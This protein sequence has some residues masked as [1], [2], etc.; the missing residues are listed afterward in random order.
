[1]SSKWYECCLLYLKIIF[2]SFF[3]L[4]HLYWGIIAL[5]WCVSFCLITKWISYTYTCIPIS[6]PSCI[7][8][9]PSLSH[10]SRWSQSTELISLCC[11]AASYYIS[12]FLIILIL[13]RISCEHPFVY[14][15]TFIR[16]SVI[17]F[18]IQ[19]YFR[20]LFNVLL[21]ILQQSVFIYPG[22]LV[23]NLVNNVY[24]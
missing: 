12:F 6:P 14:K 24:C 17:L 2:I 11:V 23:F 5:Q 18:I 10:P 20:Y 16:P 1:M 4:K 3:F 8:L 13:S 22:I 9:L 19:K 7:S 21:F 15:L